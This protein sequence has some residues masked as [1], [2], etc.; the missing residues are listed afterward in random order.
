MY[1]F[2]KSESRKNTNAEKYTLMQEK[3]DTT[4]IIPLWIA[5]MDLD[6]PDFVQKALQKR[7]EHPIFGYEMFPISSY[8]A[9]I[10]WLKRH[11]NTN[12]KLSEVLYSHS[13]TSSIN[14]VIEAFTNI[15]D[16]VIVQTPV[17]APFFTSVK[18]Q[19]RKVLLNPLVQDEHGYYKFNIE[20]L[21]NKIDN[22][23]KLLLLC[24]PA[25]PVGRAW[26]KKEL[27]EILELCIKN[28]IVVFSDEVHCDLVYEP[29]RHIPFSTLKGAENITISAYGVGKSF[30]ISGLACSTIYIQNQELKDKF[31][32]VY[33]KYHLGQ[34]NSL[35][36]V[37]FEAAYMYGDDWNK[38]LKEHLY[39]NYKSLEKVISKYQNLI[40]MAKQEATYLAWLDCRGFNMSDKKINSFF[41]NEVKL[42]LNRGLFFGNNGRG[43]I[44]LNFAV[45]SAVMIEVTN[46]L[47]KALEKLS[48]ENT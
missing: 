36:H 11:H 26:S 24:N 27:E 14:I 2:E 19:N 30:N 47:D 16:N 31:L 39:K 33:S 41:I 22:K 42:G 25:N 7:L 1:S 44:R 37:A 8:E 21:K 40:K 6:S 23:T 32:D 28:D 15:G 3:F 10:D 38:D 46:R 29:Y 9:Q 45:S 5:D 12:Y 4:D 18:Q 35:S 48:I 17:Y 13:V 34:G 20:E 43:H